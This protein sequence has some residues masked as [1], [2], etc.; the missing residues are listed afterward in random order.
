MPY[1]RCT[2]ADRNGRK[3]SVVRE[4]ANEEEIIVSYNGTD[5]LL[6]SCIPVD[7]YAISRFKRGFSRKTVLEF[8]EI[9][10][11]LLKSGLTI[12]DAIGLCVTVSGNSKTAWL[13]RNLLD[14]LN[15]G[16]PLHEA[17]KMHS[18]SF[19]SLYQSLVKLGEETGSV[20]SVFD[21]MTLYLRNE[22][23]IRGKIGNVIWYP[24]LVLLITF[25]GCIGIMMFVLPRMAEI[26]FAFN[27]SDT[28][29]VVRELSG[30][31]RS[32]WFTTIFFVFLILSS[33]FIFTARKTREHIAFLTDAL[34]LKIPFLGSFIK[35][36]QTMDFSFAMEMLTGSGITIHHALGETARAV[37]NRA[38]SKAV[39][40]VRQMLIKGE[41]LSRSFFMHKEFPPYIATWIAV[42][43]RTGEV[44]KVF[45]QIRS[46]FEEDVDNMSERLMGMLEP[47]L[48]ILVGGIVLF[49]IIQFIV[50]IFSLY[51]RL[52]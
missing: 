11:A 7:D 51:G 29:T 16:L 21:R 13:S 8:T 5:H 3:S 4:A 14:A 22:K 37:T 28:D 30:V 12:Q 41:V 27:I 43:E 17:F 44:E 39:L 38:Y 49:L 15:N 31:Y 48:I 9:M 23:K 52:L 2:L 25:A 18:P 46:F 33:V 19:S 20:A 32:L 34:I 1:Y 36:K 47:G 45:T 50:P 42:G 35:S 26:F 24:L 10:A 6:V 40:D